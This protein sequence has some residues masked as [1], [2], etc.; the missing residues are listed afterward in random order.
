M[1][2]ILILC[3]LMM[4]YRMCASFSVK[5]LSELFRVVFTV[6]NGGRRAS[7]TCY[8]SARSLRFEWPRRCGSRRVRR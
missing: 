5:L 6:S 2:Y 1:M 7:S 3:I 4:V 8:P